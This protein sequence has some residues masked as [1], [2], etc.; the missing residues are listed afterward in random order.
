MPNERVRP[1]EIISS[2]LMNFILNK[3]DELEEAVGD[4]GQTNQVRIDEITPA[5]GGLVNGT[6]TIIGA[7]FL[8]PPGDNVVRIAGQLVTEFD[9]PS[10][11]GT[12]T[13]R[14]PATIAITNP[15]GEEV[16]IRIENSGF[17][18]TE[19]SYRLFPESTQ[20]PVSIISVLRASGSAVLNT[21]QEA[22][23]TGDNFSSDVAQNEVQLL[24]SVSDAQ[25]IT[26]AVSVEEV[27]STTPGDMQVRI[28]IPEITELPLNIPRPMTLRF[29]VD[30]Q[31]ASHQ[32]SVR[33]TQ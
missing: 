7:N 6:I 31:V 27:I 11:N 33:R 21:T 2:D 29:T 26:R 12:L 18:A 24:E 13:C 17:G 1:G 20:P 19:A 32:V 8:H 5:A 25:T 14:V 10:N 30:Q 3:L 15:L 4:I 9:A 22:I 16:V 23:I 28:T